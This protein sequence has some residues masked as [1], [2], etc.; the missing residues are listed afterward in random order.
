ME[1]AH[2]MQE[3]TLREEYY[4]N[5]LTQERIAK[6]YG[7]SRQLVNRYFNTYGLRPLEPYE[8]N[9][10]HELTDVQSE[11]L[12]GTMIGDGCLQLR[13]F[14]KNAYLT[15]KHSK[16]QYEYV[17][18][19]YNIMKPFVNMEVKS[20]T[21]YSYGK[22]AEKVYF[23]TICHPVFTGL[24]RMFYDSGVKVVTNEIV[25]MITP[26]SI[27]VWF[28]DDGFTNGTNLV[29]ATESF[30]EEELERLQNMLKKKFGVHTTLWFSKYRKGSN[31]KMYK[32][33]ALKKSVN[34]LASIIEPFVLPS[35]KYKLLLKS[36]LHDC[37]VASETTCEAPQ[38][39]G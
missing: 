17:V 19:K 15:V 23:R 6:K 25:D 12:I 18:W 20:T 10:T 27:A 38:Q 7:V 32:L 30:V 14:G 36:T 1:E 22:P 29:F 11:F 8:R 33:A 26:F 31:Q 21:D 35:M 2:N 16:K 13:D 39:R 5:K 24:Y 28:M 3:R 4:N 9:V 37:S 34:D